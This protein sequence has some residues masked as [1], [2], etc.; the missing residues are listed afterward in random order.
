MLSFFNID[1][2]YLI[3]FFS[4]LL[5][6]IIFFTTKSLWPLLFFGF[7][8][9]LLHIHLSKLLDF[10]INSYLE[11][12]WFINDGVPNEIIISPSLDVKKQQIVALQ[13]RRYLSFHSRMAPIYVGE[14]EIRNYEYTKLKDIFKKYPELRVHLRNNNLVDRFTYALI[15]S[16]YNDLKQ[17]N[18]PD[19]QYVLAVAE[20]THNETE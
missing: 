12:E 4:F 13:I 9:V 16:K 5:T 10:E 6:L 1:R 7:L 18:N 15:K 14:C 8:V 17:S 19:K 20:T 3:G 2:S 11:R